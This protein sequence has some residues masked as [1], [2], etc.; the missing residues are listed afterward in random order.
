MPID[1]FIITVFCWVELGLE[2]V[3]AGV[4]LRTRVE[5]GDRVEIGTVEIGDR[6]RFPANGNGKHGLSP[7]SAAL[8]AMVQAQWGA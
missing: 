3:T 4:K 1:E 8:S 7:I 5:I 2:K 6:P